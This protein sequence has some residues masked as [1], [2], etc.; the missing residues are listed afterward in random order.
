MVRRGAVTQFPVWYPTH[1]QEVNRNSILMAQL[2]F[3]HILC[4]RTQ[5]YKRRGQLPLPKLLI[6]IRTNDD[7]DDVNDVARTTAETPFPHLGYIY[8]S[9]L[10]NL[11]HL[12]IWYSLAG[13]FETHQQWQAITIDRL[14]LMDGLIGVRL[15][16]IPSNTLGPCLDMLVFSG[17]KALPDTTC[18]HK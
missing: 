5:H 10:C 4:L 14:D 17:I 16:N 1:H 18:T 11:N 12:L 15:L 6:T 7:D 3:R 13:P 8:P 9:G 2:T